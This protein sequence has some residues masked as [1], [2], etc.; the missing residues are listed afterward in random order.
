[1]KIEFLGTSAAWPLPRLNCNC[2]LCSS[3][4]PKDKRKRSIVLINDKLLIDAGYDAYEQIKSK[5]LN[6]LRAVCVTHEHPDHLAGL[7]DLDHIY[8]RKK[9]LELFIN[10]ETWKKV[11]RVFQ[12][13]KQLIFVEPFV[14]YQVEEL[15]LSFLP[16]NHTASSFGILVSEAEKRFFYAPDM[17]SLPEKTKH[18][19]HEVDA[20]AFDGSSTTSRGS[21]PGHQSMETGISLSKELNAKEVYF[22]HIGHLTL[23]FDKLAKLLHEKGGNNFHEA[24]DGLE[25][26]I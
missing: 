23:P 2:E 16:V 19:L 1:M 26:N 10:K 7:P 6:K 18:L 25:L 5:D 22:T 3:R 9:E 20:I 21:T 4:N 15:K 8:N 14:S 13:R 11:N 17:G 24:F 12:W